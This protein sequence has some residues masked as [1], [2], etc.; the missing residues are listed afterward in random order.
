PDG[1]NQREPADLHAEEVGRRAGI[2]AAPDVAVARAADH[3]AVVADGHD[4]RAPPPVAGAARAG[5]PA[6]ARAPRPPVVG[7][8]EDRPALADD[9]KRGLP[10]LEYAVEI[11]RRAGRPR[12]PRLAPIR[13]LEDG[14][15]VA[16]GEAR[17]ERAP[18]PG[19]EGHPG[20]VL[21]GPAFA[22]VVGLPDA[23]A[24]PVRDGLPAALR[25]EHVVLR[26]RDVADVPGTGGVA[27]A[28]GA[29]DPAH[30]RLPARGLDDAAEA[31]RRADGN[32]RPD[33][34]VG[35]G[36]DEAAVTDD[37]A[38]A[39]VATA[40]VVDGVEVD[41]GAEVYGGPILGRSGRQGEKGECEAEVV[42]HGSV[43]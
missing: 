8:D 20:A 29:A 35:R 28:D 24:G 14:P 43:G 39:G 26:A 10:T 17:L 19:V 2:V 31:R 38:G 4:A 13:R 5:G 30:P 42:S 32:G 33:E 34:V 25:G 41:R 27:H 36:R 1:L 7:A 22:E 3:R 21:R 15:V 40:L 6:P 37:V 16:D 18:V 9:V 12:R 23:P 11:G